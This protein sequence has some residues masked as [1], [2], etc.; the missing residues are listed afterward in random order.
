[1][2]GI[3]IAL[4]AMLTQGIENTYAKKS[5]SE[6]GTYKAIVNGYIVVALLL[7]LTALIF[8]QPFTFPKELFIP[9]IVQ[10]VV[11]I[12][13]IVAFFKALEKGMVSIISPLSKLHVLITIGIG[14]YFFNESF[15]M[16]QLLG[17]VLISISAL[18]LAFENL[19]RAKLEQGVPYLFVA[20]LGHGYYFSFIKLFIPAL[21]PFMTTV[22]LET[23]ITIGIVAYFTVKNKEFWL[24]SWRKGKFSILRGLLLSIFTVLHTYSIGFIGV[25]LTSAVLAGSPIVTAV[26]SYFS[27]KEKLTIHKY[28][29]ITL[30]VAGLIL[31]F[32]LK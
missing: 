23:G 32:A 11:G 7:I 15:S 9:Y 18:L 27:L 14:I 10:V 19:R 25:A 1:M 20:V 16:G 5:I 26:H 4:A 13:S 2:L 17:A 28:A 22:A 31:I 6:A 24:P 12:I 30:T 3:L 21:G 29:A 8:R